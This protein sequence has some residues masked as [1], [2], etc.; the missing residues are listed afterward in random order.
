MESRIIK[1]DDKNKFSVYVIGNNVFLG[2]AD[3]NFAKFLKFPSFIMFSK[4]NDEL[5]I[6]KDPKWENISEN[7][8]KDYFLKLDSFVKSA[9]YCYKRVLSLIGLGYRVNLVDNNS[10]LECKIGFSHLKYLKIP[11]EIRVKVGGK[12][13]VVQLE[14]LNKMLLGNFVGK[15]I[16]LRTPD[17]YKGKGFSLRY[18]QKK[19][20]PIK[21]K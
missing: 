18:Q 3:L 2:G 6:T 17:S 7:S 14:G 4:K 1:L 19:L 5:I 10:K 21:K 16:R 9:N 11:K 12:K 13:N 15:M 8:V 20:K